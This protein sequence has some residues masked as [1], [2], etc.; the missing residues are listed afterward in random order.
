[1]SLS[2]LRQHLLKSDNIF[3]HIDFFPLISLVKCI[4]DAYKIRAG[5]ASY[6]GRAGGGEEGEEKRNI[7]RV[8]LRTR[9]I[10]TQIEEKG[11]IQ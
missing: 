7:Q 5:K 2:S 9:G 1:M 8:I 6:L 11:D 4:Q 10:E 3:V